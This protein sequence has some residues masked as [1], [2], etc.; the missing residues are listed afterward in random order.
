VEGWSQRVNEL[1]MRSL[2]ATPEPIYYTRRGGM[3]LV[4]IS[5]TFCYTQQYL[6]SHCG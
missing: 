6:L 5:T 2:S 4:S 1:Y 3:S